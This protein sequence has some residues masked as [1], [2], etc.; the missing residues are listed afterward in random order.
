MRR[1][2]RRFMQ[3][4]VLMVL[5]FCFGTVACFPCSAQTDPSPA[6]F[7]KK[8]KATKSGK[9]V[10][11]TFAVDRDTDVAVYVLDAK[12]EIVRHL[13]A[14]VL[15]KNAPA[16]L[17]S[18]SL[19]QT[20]EWDGKDDDG[21]KAAGG[22]FK[23]RVGIGLKANYGGVAF[24]EH[25]GPNH[26]S[27]VEGMAIGSN[28]R[29]YVID[30]RTGWLYWPGKS[31]HIFRR[32]GSYE[33]TIKP[34]PANVP[35]NRIQST[36]AFKNDRGYL[37]PILHRIQAMSFYPYEDTPA[38]QMVV[39]PK[40]NLIFP[41]VPTQNKGDSADRGVTP[42]LAVIG[43]DGGTLL[44]NYA[45]P[46]LGTWKFGEPYLVAASD[47]KSLYMTGPG[48]KA[49]NSKEAQLHPAIYR[50]PIPAL[51]PA[52]VFFGNPETVGDDK[53][54][55][56]N[57]RGLALD[58]K[59]NL[60][61]ADF[62]SN[63]V[64]VIK[65]SNGSFVSSF[66]VEMP[67]W[68]GVNPKNGVVYVC[69]KDSLVKFSGWKN[70]TEQ[71]RID[72]GKGPK[73]ERRFSRSFALDHS[74][75]PVK[76]WVG[77]NRSGIA[78]QSCK[79]LGDKFSKLEQAGYFASPKHWRPTADPTKKIVGCRVGGSWSGT[80]HVMEEATG[81]THG[82]KKAIGEGWLQRLDRDG[83]IYVSAHNKGLLRLD[84][85]GKPFPFKETENDSDKNV[86]GRLPDRAGATGTTAWERDF[87]VDRKGDI[88]VKIRGKEYHGLMHVAVYGQDGKHKRNVLW[89]VTD[90]S[91]GPRLDP[92]GNMYLM[93]S[94]KPAGQPFPAE[95]KSHVTDKRVKKWYDWIYGSIIKF[96]PAGGNLYLPNAHKED[97]F[98]KA[99]PIKLPKT[100]KKEEVLSTYRSKLGKS[101]LQGALWLQPGVAHCGDMGVATTGHHCH[102]TGCD[103]DVD[104]F[105]RTFAPDNGRQRVTVFDTNGNVILHFGA[106]G[107]QDYCGSDSYVMD[108]KDKFLRPRQA[109]DPKNLVSPF[110]E[111]EIAF[112]FIIG[113]AVTDRYAYVADCANR[114]MLKCKLDYAA[115]E[116][117]RIR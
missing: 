39:T 48:K 66:P 62:G 21:E 34:F 49:S 53:L 67:T 16:P 79:D 14:G 32:D 105:G 26:I 92:S 41:V 86:K 101:Y 88:Y 24:S 99:D 112:N 15:G 4:S 98:P 74:A 102:C 36:Q 93:E 108:P 61:V 3:Q 96:S 52:E 55:L 80:F 71:A 104:N 106:Y 87:S 94:V 63:R 89:G 117:C 109:S 69:S 25:A 22:P 1:F 2:T 85:N 35:L 97:G 33:K 64:V 81:K 73:Y 19:S 57:P 37:N 46:K 78:L 65:E 51:G 40:G 114:R 20:I 29:L 113:L 9:K 7:T 5:V 27:N 82:V 115:E 91:Y 45:G 12:G 100:V 6:K 103:F 60:L 77:R 11:V 95:F 43:L 59:G 68:V 42:H 54:H 111:P 31:I 107:N 75:K 38:R 76:I 28:G 47:G 18:K 23:I 70:P 56:S 10:K 50:V 17:Q 13:A 84:P 30:D 116:V 83:N 58:G 90:G 8:P 110:A 44:P 72:L